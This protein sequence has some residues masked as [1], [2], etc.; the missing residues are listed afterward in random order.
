M[1]VPRASLTV[2]HRAM[3]FLM[4]GSS[5]R[6]SGISRVR[7][8]SRSVKAVE[9]RASPRGWRRGKFQASLTIL[10]ASVFLWAVAHVDSFRGGQHAPDVGCPI[11]ILVV[12]RAHDLAVTLGSACL[13]VGLI[14]IPPRRGDCCLFLSVPQIRSSHPALS[15]SPL[16]S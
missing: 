8:W 5:P 11:L 14:A 4:S 6:T 16:A 7:R 3:P 1:G 13:L 2:Q 10:Q 12:L 15:L 9:P